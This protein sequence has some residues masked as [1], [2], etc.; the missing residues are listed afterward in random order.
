MSNT[1]NERTDWIFRVTSNDFL[2]L[3]TSTLGGNFDLFH[4]KVFLCATDIILNGLEKTKDIQTLKLR[5]V[6]LSQKKLDELA[7]FLFRKSMFLN[8]G[9]DLKIYDIESLR[10]A[11][12]YNMI[13]DAIVY[14]LQNDREISF[15]V[16]IYQPHIINNPQ[17]IK[18][19]VLKNIDNKDLFYLFWS[20]ALQIGFARFNIFDQ[21]LKEELEVRGID[22]FDANALRKYLNGMNKEELLYILKSAIKQI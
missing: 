19:N 17:A 14:I 15:D 8:F 9:L 11:I 10:T 22:C 13:L 1:S 4:A 3:D 2:N 16:G 12:I 5:D 21:F 7:Y 20:A 18:E 6:M